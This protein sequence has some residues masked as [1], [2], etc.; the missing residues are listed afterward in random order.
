MGQS[1]GICR[2]VL[3]QEK[4]FLSIL[5][6]LLFSHRDSLGR[7]EALTAKIMNTSLSITALH[8]VLTRLA[9]M[10]ACF[11]ILEPA[12]ATQATDAFSPLSL[13]LQPNFVQQPLP[14]WASS[15]PVVQSESD[16]VLIPVPPLATQDA[17][18]CFALTVVFQDRGDGGPVVEWQPKEGERILLSAGLGESGV[19]LGLNAHTL[20][21]SQSDRKSVV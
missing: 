9:V 1:A 18:G 4:R 16:T 14:S 13:T 21:I 11:L 19:S 20:L 12:Q 3:W 8:R 6:F 5:R 7:R 15:K 17:I 2:E 10:V